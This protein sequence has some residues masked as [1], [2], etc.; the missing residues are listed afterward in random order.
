MS[1]TRTSVA[2]Q[3]AATT[4]PLQ[5][6]PVLSPWRR[7][8][9]DTS[10]WF[11][12]VEVARGRS[13]NRPLERLGRIRLA[14]G[15]AVLVAFVVG[16]VG[17]RL[18]SALE[19]PWWGFEVV[20]MVVV[21][22]LA[23]L[24]YAPWF[25]AHRALFYDKRWG[26][27][28]QTPRGFAL[29]Q[30]K[31]VGFELVV[32]A[33]LAV[34]LYAVIRATDAW[35][36]FGW[37]VLVAFT[38]LFGYLYPVLIAP[39]FN[40]FEPLGDERL[41]QRLLQVAE[42][43]GLHVDRVLVADASRRSRVGNAYVAGLGRTRRVVLF[44]TIL[45]WPPAVVEQV[46]AHELG[47]WKHAHLRRRLPIVMAAQLVMFATA[48]AALQWRPLLRAAGV[49]DVSDPASLPLLVAVLPL[50]LVLTGLVSSWLSRVDERQADL[51]ALETLDAPD[52]LAD[53]LRRLARRNRAD[54]DPSWWKRM[55]ASHPPIAERMAMAAAWKEG[56]SSREE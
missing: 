28:T 1:R 40:R 7:V 30:V 47:H 52:S 29:D 9:A 46:V 20:A 23:S 55:T 14:L 3:P 39:L 41:S 15:A 53:L 27:S 6:A 5:S 44:D 34:A 21:L 26:L 8:P 37:L 51:F 22:Q 54:V 33:V 31:Q 49:Q 32:S 43:A 25:R 2:S 24:V 35:W 36:F 56:G 10:A 45:D 4:P 48:W 42:R 12:P 38:V 19:L 11:D 13:Y 16:Q 50:G 17:P 18:L